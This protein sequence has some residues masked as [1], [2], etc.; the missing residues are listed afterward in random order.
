MKEKKEDSVEIKIRIWMLRN[1]LNIVKIAKD[2]GAGR[3]FVSQLIH[4]L[5]TSR[6][7]TQHMIDMGC[8]KECFKNGRLVKTQQIKSN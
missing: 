4:G 6:G 8:P 5:K 3:A 7:L 2:Y 1:N